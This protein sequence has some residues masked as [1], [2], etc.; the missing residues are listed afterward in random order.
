MGDATHLIAQGTGEAIK[1]FYEDFLGA[2]VSPKRGGYSLHF[3][4]GHCLQ[5]T[6]TFVEDESISPICQSE[7]GEHPVPGICIYMPTQDMF[8]RA[9][10]RCS[11]AGLVIADHSVSQEPQQ[12]KEFVFRK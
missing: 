3:S 8:N 4:L 9:F 7:V 5:Q 11:E 10:M 1:C 12:L 2:A 6:L